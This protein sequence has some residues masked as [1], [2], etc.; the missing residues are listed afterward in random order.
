MKKWLYPCLWL[1]LPLLLAGCRSAAPTED[2]PP[3]RTASAAWMTPE[4]PML[5]PAPCITY[6]APEIM[7][8]AA[9]LDLPP[10]YTKLSQADGTTCYCFTD[11]S[12]AL[13]YRVVVRRAEYTDG[14]ETGAV[15]SVLR[16]FC[17]K[18]R[19]TLDESAPVNLSEEQPGVFL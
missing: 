15:V 13:Q 17:D 11:L 3:D 8:D 18:G 16:A 12:G 2:A 5:T 14:A 10:Y 9:G 6:G 4:A 7:S 19:L 1:C